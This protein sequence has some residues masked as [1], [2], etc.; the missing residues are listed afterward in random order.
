[1]QP[2]TNSHCISVSYARLEAQAA[3]CNMA[4]DQGRSKLHGA[5]LTIMLDETLQRAFAD[6]EMEDLLSALGSLDGVVSEPA[7]AVCVPITNTATGEVIGS[8]SSSAAASG[9][10]VQSD[11]RPDE[12]AETPAVARIMRF[13]KLYLDE[14]GAEGAALLTERISSSQGVVIQGATLPPYIG[15]V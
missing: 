1:M 15:T 8:A 14:K 5:A 12:P 10:A 9:T 13:L 2:I 3:S 11:A 6:D 4:I 7:A